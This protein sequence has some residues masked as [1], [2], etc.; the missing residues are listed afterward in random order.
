[1]LAARRAAR[2]QWFP[3]GREMRRL[4]RLRLHVIDGGDL[5]AEL[6][7]ASR[8]NVNRSFIGGLFEHGRARAQQWLQ[9]AAARPSDGA[10][11]SVEALLFPR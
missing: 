8:L 2:R 4:R 11:E 1:V 6:P 3:I 9:D 5:T 7:P 10:P